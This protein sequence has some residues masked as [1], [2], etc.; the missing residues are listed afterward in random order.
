MV[1]EDGV[2]IAGGGDVSDYINMINTELM[3]GCG[4]DILAMDILPFYEYARNGPLTL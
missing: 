2:V 1:G 4:P 3:S